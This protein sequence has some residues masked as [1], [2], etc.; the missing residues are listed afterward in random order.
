[1]IFLKYHRIT[2]DNFIKG[3]IKSMRSSFTASTFSTRKQTDDGK[4][5]VKPCGPMTVGDPLL[6]KTDQSAHVPYEYKFKVGSMS[7]RDR[8]R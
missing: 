2:E 7:L 4:I 1:M 8:E 3:M 5:S 6:Q